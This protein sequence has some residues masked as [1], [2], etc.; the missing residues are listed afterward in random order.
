VADFDVVVIG[1]GFG[2]AVTA[3]RLAEAGYRVVVLERGRRW[4]PDNFPRSL[5]DAWVWDNECPEK[6]NGWMEL[7]LF[8]NMAV[9]QG[10]GVG[11]G[12]LIYANVSIEAKPDLF[13]T[14]WPEEITYS[15]LKPYYDKVG[16]ML[17]LQKI[18]ENQWSERTRLMKEAADRA[19]YSDRFS[20]L[21]LAVT[22]DPQWHYG[23][24]DPHHERH[25]K[26]F[27]NE[28]GQQQG[29]C[30][31]LGNC[32]VGCDVKAK[33]TLDLNYIPRAE[34]QGAEVRPLH[35]VRKILPET[36]RYRVVFDRIIG[37]KVVEGSVTGR[38]VI[39]AAGS[40]N[41]TE[42]LL[43][44]RD[45]FQTLPQ[46]SGFLGCNWSSNGD[47]LT[48][49]FYF[50]RSVRPSRGPTITCYIDFLG[51]RNLNGQHFI[52]EDGGFPDIAKN[53]MESQAAKEGGAL[54]NRLLLETFRHVL[55]QPSLM[56]SVMPW[57]GM[58]RDAADGILSLRR[59]FV[60]FGSRYLHLN[61]DIRKSEETIEAIIAMHR[62]FSTLTRGGPFVPLTWTLSKDLITPHPLGGCNMGSSP[63]N[64]VVDHRGEVFGYRNLFVADGSIVPEAVG[65]NPSKTIAALAERIAALIVQEGR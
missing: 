2:G 12:S 32:V 3:C 36:E 64:G 40:I 14:G 18:P 49:A 4:T 29:T 9:A 57:F 19:G 46:L 54:R 20:L 55:R 65:A 22:F 23:L 61:W 37:N 38:L 10:A 11:G 53:F 16:S 45:E 31:H 7:R 27:V 35:L 6:A 62:K 48:P 47:F 33:N 15:E 43:R 21:D 60:F 17:A 26:K 56:D 63:A 25:S 34:Q 41:S 13:E 51:D 42:L 58:G 24:E 30:V 28:H 39:L 52:V 1:S 59:R 44:C 50:D 8:P 5:N